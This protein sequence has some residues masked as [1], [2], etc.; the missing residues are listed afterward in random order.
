MA[1]DVVPG[2]LEDIQSRFRTNM[3]KSQP[4]QRVRQRMEAGTATLRDVHTYTENVGHALSDAMRGALT[5]DKL[6]DG[7]MWYNIA[8]RTLGPMVRQSYDMSN[9]VATEI[10]EARDRAEGLGLNAVTADYP[11]NRVSGLVRKAADAADAGE[12]W[13]RWFGEP[14]V[15]LVESLADSFMKANA[16]FREKLGMSPRIRRDSYAR[17]CDWCAGLDGVYD[18]KD[19]PRE[20]YARHEFCRCEV[21]FENGNMRQ[22]VWTKERWTADRDE[23]DR[24]REYGLTDERERGRLRTNIQFFAEKGLTNQTVPQ[25]RSG[26]R[27]FQSRIEE[28]KEYIRNP[29]NHVPNWDSLSEAEKRGNIKHWNKEIRNFEESIQ[30]RLNEI[31]RR[32]KK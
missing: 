1:E 28:H 22:N 24:R 32:A 18:Y 21:T 8:D 25:L 31:E 13:A 20:V 16:D 6:P 4:L 26:I 9:Q 27:S 12:D 17:C 30:N 29:K 2:L 3:N 15:N 23:L 19:A 11:E 14:V 10:L 7:R 5:P